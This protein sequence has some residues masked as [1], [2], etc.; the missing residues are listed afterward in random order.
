M[1]EETINTLKINNKTPEDVLWCGSEEFGW[2]YF[3]DFIEIAP[4]YYNSGFGGQEI[5]KDL[6]IVGDN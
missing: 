6:L 5:S 2:F 4:E 3:D 1:K